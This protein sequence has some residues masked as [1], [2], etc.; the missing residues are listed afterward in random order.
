MYIVVVGGGKVGYSLTRA[1]LAEGQ[2]VLVIE[3]QQVKVDRIIDELGGT[4]I[5]GDGAEVT[6]LE[7]AGLERADVVA[8]VTGHDEDNLIVCQVAK[9]R[10]NVPRT[11]ARINN[12]RNEYIFTELG[13]DATV[14]ATQVILAVI[15]QEIPHH[16]L[17]HL[18]TL[19]EG[20]VEFLQLELTEDSPVVGRSMGQLSLPEDTAVPLL[21]RDGLPVV[22]HADTT[23]RAR[24]RLIAVVTTNQESALRD[25]VL[26]EP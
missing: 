20:G 25:Y 13:I 11:V 10:F 23:F 24:D 2:E 17:V 6:T 16:P 5:Q 3:K 7:L 9:R 22:V 15:Q 19:R 4:A 14:S 18:L 12:P 26:G 21:M 1:L 8:A